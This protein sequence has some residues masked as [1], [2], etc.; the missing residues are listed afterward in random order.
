MDSQYT[1]YK[2]KNFRMTSYE[3]DN[4]LRPINLVSRKLDV[5]ATYV[6]E[7]QDLG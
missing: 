5:F 1:M 7:D 2:G 4:C 6:K 3:K